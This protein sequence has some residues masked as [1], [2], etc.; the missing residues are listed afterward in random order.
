MDDDT[1]PKKRPSGAQR[2]KAE[3]EAREKRLASEVGGGEDFDVLGEPDLSDPDV[4]L[5]YVRKAQLIAF[6]QICRS[7]ALPQMERWKLIREH[8][9]TLGMTHPRSSLEARTQRIEKLMGEKTQSPAV[10][11]ETGVQKPPTARGMRRGP[12]PL[13]PAP[14]DSEDAPTDLPG[15][16]GE[17][18]S[19]SDPPT[20]PSTEPTTD[21]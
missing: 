16:H 6:A 2:R 10:R 20:D 21:E 9:A 19:A 4:G 11:W 8:A 15:A 5:A 14:P 7:R 18:A 3:R 12:R 17:G 13:P 1:P